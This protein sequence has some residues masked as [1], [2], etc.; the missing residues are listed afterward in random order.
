MAKTETRKMP[1]EAAD[2]MTPGAA[3]R[4][5]PG[6]AGGI[7]VDVL[8]RRYAP[9]VLRRCRDILRNEDAAADAMQE[10]FVRVLRSRDSL[11]A[12]YPSS[13]LYRIATNVC[14]NVVR[15]ARRKPEMQGGAVLECM[16]GR[17]NVEDFALNAVLVE[18]VFAGVKPSTRR[19]AEIHYRENA[20]LE[21]TAERVGLSISGVRKRLDGLRRQSL[22]RV[23]G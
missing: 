23:A 5:P 2:R 17:D 19:A 14:L 22:A 20:T 12:D 9:M 1:P 3:D 7:D 8:Y 21:E 15:S 11:R 4:M 18:H 16:P 6:A 10:T 13:L